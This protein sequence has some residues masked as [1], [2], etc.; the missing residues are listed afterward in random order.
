MRNWI[1]AI[2]VPLSTLAILLLAACGQQTVG[3]A[4]SPPTLTPADQWPD[5]RF[6]QSIPKPSSGTVTAVS[7][8]N[9]AGYQIFA[10]YLD[11]IGEAEVDAYLQA[12]QEA[13]FQSVHDTLGIATENAVALGELFYNG[14]VSLSVAASGSSLSLA[15]SLP[16]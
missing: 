6:T 15:V 2:L 4:T 5:N 10:V 3:S 12:V 1:R 13:G 7:E 11:D 16:E 9:S 8:G 14:E